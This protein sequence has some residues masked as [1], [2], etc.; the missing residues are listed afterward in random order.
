VKSIAMLPVATY[1]KSYVVENKV[2]NFVAQNLRTTGYRWVTSS[3]ARD[4]LGD[5][6]TKVV[7]EDVLKNARVDSLVAPALCARL[8]TNAVLAVRVD[9]WEQQP[10]LWNQSG[11][12]TTSVQ[13]KAALV[14][15]SGRLLWSASGSETGEGPYHDPNTNPISVAGSGLE[16]APV[17]GQGGPPTYDEIVN[18]LL[19]RW[20]PQF[21]PR[22]AAAPAPAK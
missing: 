6:V 3:V 17:T 19:L 21:P 1:D 14:D 18:K 10:I 9:Q 16:N 7:R 8:R 13:L 15:S 2:G 5:S 22:A 12:P 20:A 11:K 4:M